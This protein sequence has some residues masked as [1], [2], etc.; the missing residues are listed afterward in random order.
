M[1][2][3]VEQ[4]QFYRVLLCKQLNPRLE[5][6][7]VRRWTRVTYSSVHTLIWIRNSTGSKVDQSKG[8]Q[9]LLLTTAVDSLRLPGLVM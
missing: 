6:R 2:H 7:L 9:K 5:I 8:L 1:L 3:L 4:L